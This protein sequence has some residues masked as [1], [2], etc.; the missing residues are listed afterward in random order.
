MFMFYKFLSNLVTCSRMLLLVSL[1]LFAGQCDAADSIRIFPQRFELHGPESLQRIL[2]TSVS[3]SAKRLPGPIAHDVTIETSDPDV[4]IVT[5]NIVH[6]VGNGSAKI[7]AKT[8]DGRIAEAVLE[9]KNF[10]HP[11]AW[12]FRHEVESVFARLGCSMGACHGALAGKGGFR[13]SL[14]GYDPAADWQTITLEALGRRIELADPGRSLLLAKP[15]GALPHKGGLKLNFDARDYQV[16]SGWIADGATGPQAT[17]P[18]LERI[19]VMPEDSMLMPGDRGQVLVQAHYSDGLVK[20]VTHWAKFSATD[21]AIAGVDESGKVDIRGSGQGAV[22]AWFGSKVALA[23]LTVPYANDLS[24]DVYA[25][26]PRRN[27]IDNLILDQ[28]ET[29]KLEPSPRCGDEAFIR[30]ATIDT[31]GRLPS[32]DEVMDFLADQHSNKRDHYIDSLLSTEEFVDY[33]SYKWSDLLLINGTKLRP[34]AVKAY[35]GWIRESVSKNKPWDQLV[36]EILTA[37]GSSIDNGAT[38][39]Y[40]LHQDPEN[41]TENAAQAFLGLSIGCAKCHNHP[42]EKWTN[43]Q[44]Y[45]FANLFSRVRAKGWGGDS[46]NG[47]GRRTV[48]VTNQGELLQPS[49]GKPQPPAPLDSEPLDFDDPRDRRLVLAEWLTSPENPYFSRAITNRIW[50]NFYGVALVEAADDLRLSNPASNEALLDEAA[51][52]LAENNFDLKTLMREILRSE[53]YQRSSQPLPTNADES[54]YYS[55][56]YPRRMMAE[57]LLDSIDQSLATSTKFDTVAFPGA[58]KN[59]TDFYPE[60]TKAIELYDS[61]VESYF[62]TTF[63]RNTREITC[64]CERSDEP[65]MVQVLHMSNGET[66]NPKLKAEN[67]RISQW[68]TEGLSNEEIIDRLFI[69]TLAR[70]PG[71]NEKNSLLKVM[72]EYEEGARREAIEDACWSVLTSGEFIFNH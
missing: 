37:T 23:R 49:T 66:L 9:V 27:F 64:E 6:P 12:S 70:Y 54:R 25:N 69:V 24:P 39:F 53:A 30:R 36:R 38:N 1:T 61:A 7:I 29:L 40:A 59:A 58:D 10:E 18:V 26:A 11:H 20:D 32:E 50:K 71:E 68:I 45:G 41:M 63:G 55:R 48:Y 67:N 35:Y 60:G 34:E 31:I 56:Y 47:D 43:D 42:L 19:S 33:W 44:Y 72:A 57:V 14:R 5:D 16:L 13:L 2:V 4:A 46:R 51:I 17:D 62:L 3:A 15:T 21:E 22:L 28:L 65:S 52:F 8:T